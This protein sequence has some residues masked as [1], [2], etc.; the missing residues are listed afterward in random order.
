M[1]LK[2]WWKKRQETMARDDIDVFLKKDLQGYAQSYIEYR[3][4]LARKYFPRIGEDLLAQ[5]EAFLKEYSV[6]EEDFRK[7]YMRWHEGNLVGCKCSRDVV[8]KARF[9]GQNKWHEMVKMAQKM[10]TR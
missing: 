2:S 4:L 5:K 9:E 8:E 10:K 7:D 6:R 3:K 1:N